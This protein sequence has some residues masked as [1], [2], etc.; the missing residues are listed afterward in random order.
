MRREVDVESGR[1]E[2]DRSRSTSPSPRAGHIGPGPSVLEV[3]MGNLTAGS[4][5]STQERSANGER[6]GQAN[7]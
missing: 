6:A 7:L 4:N 3:D 1:D 2:S 5:P